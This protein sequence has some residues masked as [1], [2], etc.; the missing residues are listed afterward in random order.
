MVGSARS[1]S[2]S[3][4]LKAKIESLFT[5]TSIYA[6]SG[7]QESGCYGHYFYIEFLECPACEGANYNV[8]FGDSSMAPYDQGSKYTGTTQ[9]LFACSVCRQATCPNP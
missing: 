2:T 1:C 8:P 4:G 6:Q 9:C 5:L 3:N 7:C